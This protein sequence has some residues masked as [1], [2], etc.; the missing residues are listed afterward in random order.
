ML[1]YADVCLQ[2]PAH[3]YGHEGLAGRNETDV[4]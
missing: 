2:A 1:T 4:R 3:A